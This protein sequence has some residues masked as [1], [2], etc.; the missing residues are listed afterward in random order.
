MKVGIIA[1]GLGLVLTTLGILL[2]HCLSLAVVGVVMTGISF[3]MIVAAAFS[4][5]QSPPNRS[6]PG[7]N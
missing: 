6:A 5:D 7:A 1:A 2:P 3:G 4:S